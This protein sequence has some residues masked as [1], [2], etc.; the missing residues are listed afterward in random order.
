M[1]SFSLF[2]LF[3]IRKSNP[4]GPGAFFYQITSYIFFPTSSSLGKESMIGF[5]VSNVETSSDINL[6]GFRLLKIFLL[7]GSSFYLKLALLILVTYW[8][9]SVC[10]YFAK[11]L[12]AKI[13][14]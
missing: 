4:G 9:M 8:L 1:P 14:F 11:S 6:K 12:V 2:S 13:Y 7:I 10:M 3:C 5:S